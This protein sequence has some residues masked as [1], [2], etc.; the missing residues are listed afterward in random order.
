MFKKLG[1]IFTLRDLRATYKAESKVGPIYKSRK[2]RGACIAA[3]C[4]ILSVFFGMDI[5]GISIDHLTNNIDT[6]IT[7]VGGIYGFVMMMVGFF[8]NRNSS[9]K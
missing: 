3:G 6:L 4:V 8:K 1:L 7:A 2:F 5:D 9:T